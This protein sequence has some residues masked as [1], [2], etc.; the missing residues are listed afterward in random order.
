MQDQLDRLCAIALRHS[1]KYVPGDRPRVG[2][3]VGH[4]TALPEASMYEPMVC[5]VL[6]GAKQVTI[7]D[8]VLRYDPASY[9]V[10][11]LDLPAHG[12]I[13]EA[14]ADK[15][16]IAAAMTLN[17]EVLAELLCTAPERSS[18]EAAGFQVSA[19]TP[20]L[21]EAWLRLLSLFDRPE[22]VA[23]LG[24]LIEREILYR[25][26]HGPQGHMLRQAAQ[27]DSRL[28]RIRSA[29]G[30][31]RAHFTAPLRI[32]ALAEIAGMSAPSFHRHFKAATAMSPLQYQKALR[33]QEARRLLVAY[34][35]AA[36]TAYRVGYESPSQFSREYAR[37]FG[38]SPLRDAALLRGAEPQVA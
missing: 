33:L 7:G 2:V 13:I 11:A 19:M 20:E 1:G 18:G 15:P 26:L 22:E 37:M 8:R 23:I 14:S 31:I 21:L 5:V 36:A 3:Y 28:S 17:R 12:C 35:D 24:P 29:I 16:Y 32:E 6:Q 10:A 25:L 9:F 38:N 27:T 4:Q 30:W 34:G